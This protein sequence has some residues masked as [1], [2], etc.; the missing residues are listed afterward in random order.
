MSVK[1]FYREFNK[2]LSMP[3]LTA[4]YSFLKVAKR[5]YRHNQEV[6]EFLLG[7]I[8]LKNMQEM[9]LAELIVVYNELCVAAGKK[10]RKAFDSKKAA[11]EAIEKLD[12]TLQAPTQEQIISAEQSNQRSRK[13]SEVNEAGEVVAVEAKPRGKGI[14]ARAS[15][16]LIAGMATADV[17]ATIKAEIEGANPTP[18][19]IA[20]YKNK[21]RQEGKLPKPVKKDPAEKKPRTKKE[22]APAVVEGDE[23]AD[24]YDV[25]DNA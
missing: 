13:M 18:A 1:D 21:L 12:A 16:L 17:I 23:P 20:W 7:E 11:L 9:S 15:E 24:A 2:V 3:P 14:G 6:I 22:K 4:A 5:A 19:T 10:P 8:I 25:E